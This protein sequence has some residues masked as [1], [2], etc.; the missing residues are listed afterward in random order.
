MF[1]L[2]ALAVTATLAFLGLSHG[3]LAESY[4][5]RIE[6]RPF[7]GATVTLE[8]GVRVFRPLPPDRHVIINPGAQTPLSLNETNV[9]EHRVIH[10]YN[11]DQPSDRAPVIVGRRAV[12]WGTGG[13]LGR[14]LERGQYGHFGVMRGSSSFGHGHGQT[15]HGHR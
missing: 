6:T 3:A 8:E 11:Y 10:N 4:T 2:R 15:G 7:Y 9:Y 12:G 13:G 14:G 1:R 5:T